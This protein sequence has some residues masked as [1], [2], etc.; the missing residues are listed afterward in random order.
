MLLFISCGGPSSE[1]K[2]KEDL[3][4][5]GIIE[6]REQLTD[7]DRDKKLFTEVI[8]KSLN[9]DLEYLAC[10]DEQDYIPMVNHVA[11]SGRDVVILN[12]SFTAAGVRELC[13]KYPDTFFFLFSDND[14]ASEN[15][16]SVRYNM[17][18][19][20]YISG[21]VCALRSK[22]GKVG[23][24][25][26]AGSEGLFYF[27]EKGAAYYSDK[28]EVSTFSVRNDIVSS[29]DDIFKNSRADIFFLALGANLQEYAENAYKHSVMIAVFDEKGLYDYGNIIYTIK[30]K[31]HAVYISLIHRF[32]MGGAFKSPMIFGIDEG[33]FVFTYSGT[34]W[35]PS[36]KAE[37]DATVAKILGMRIR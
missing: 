22:T 35:D 26:A 31:K 15:L 33:A 20:A 5:I 8:S 3:L 30:P 7:F 34:G 13:G 32:I 23:V 21:Y 37:V 10:A 11:D 36:D 9:T 12:S 27:F 4:R 1:M 28:T 19:A 29:A 2:R 6:S 17:D 25:C 24:V 14:I 18:Q 16:K